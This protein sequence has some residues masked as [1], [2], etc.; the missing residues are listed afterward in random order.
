MSLFLIISRQDFPQYLCPVSPSL[1]LCH[2]TWSHHSGQ[3]S[4]NFLNMCN[5][6]SSQDI[7]NSSS[8]VP[9]SFFKSQLTGENTYS[10]FRLSD[11]TQNT[12]KLTAAA[13]FYRWGKRLRETKRVSQNH[14]TSNKPPATH[15]TFVKNSFPFAHSAWPVSLQFSTF[16][17]PVCFLT[18][19]S[20]SSS[21]R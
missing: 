8:Q 3:I 14:I 1:P 11:T 21:K 13:L 9:W 7:V 10:Q 12:A 18:T 6:Y 15:L 16:L 5:L 20:C 17:V 4:C 19:S 2:S